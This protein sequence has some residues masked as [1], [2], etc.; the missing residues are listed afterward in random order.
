MTVAGAYR[1]LAILQIRSVYAYRAAAFGGIGITLSRILLL[2]VVWTAAYAGAGAVDGI[3][4]HAVLTAVTLA[5]LQLLVMQPTLVT[6]LQRRIHN[7]QIGVDLVRPI[8]FLG[9]LFAQQ[10]G[11]NLGYLPF[12]VLAVPFAFVLGNLSAPVSA[13]AAVAYVVSAVLAWLIATLLGLLMGLVAF[14][15]VET[16]GITVIYNFATQLLGGALIPLAF[17]PDWLRTIAMVLPFRAIAAVPVSIYMGAVTGPGVI[18][19][20]AFQLAWIVLLTFAGWLVWR[21][22]RRIVTVQGG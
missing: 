20:M 21:R 15:T 9:G 5:Q 1:S 12:V 2:N 6:Y 8:P 18:G 13:V 14:W 7:G 11:A 4:L 10:A 17:F 16:L 3:E 19:Q 22:A